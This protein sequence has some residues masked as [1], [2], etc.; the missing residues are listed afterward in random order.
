MMRLAVTAIEIVASV[1]ASPC[2][3]QGKSDIAEVRV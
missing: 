2:A 3:A 1:A